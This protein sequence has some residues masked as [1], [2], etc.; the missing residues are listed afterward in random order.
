VTGIRTTK[1][2]PEDIF[3]REVLPDEKNGRELVETIDL[4]AKTAEEELIKQQEL[5]K[6][7]KTLKLPEDLKVLKQVP[8]PLYDIYYVPGYDEFK[9]G[10]IPDFNEDDN[11]KKSSNRLRTLAEKNI[12][13]NTLP[14]LNTSKLS[15]PN[16][17]ES[18]GAKIG[19]QINTSGIHPAKREAMNKTGEI[20]VK[21]VNAHLKDGTEYWQTTFQNNFPQYMNPSQAKA[22]Q[23]E[24][25]FHRLPYETQY[26]LGASEYR[27]SYG[28]LGSNP[29]DKLP[30]HWG[31]MQKREDTLKFGTTEC[32]N[33]PPGYTGFI[34]NT[35]VSY[36]KAIDQAKGANSRETFIKKNI[37]ENFHRQIPGY[38]GHKPRA[39]MND[40]GEV[41]DSIYYSNENTLRNV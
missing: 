9:T 39:A 7:S 33:H 22:M 1:D 34:P 19:M 37:T 13:S 36:G 17:N 16:L 6:A 10:H 2:Y 40:R 41:R 30:A 29:R 5:E 23:P 26:K 3:P 20:S 27:F 38:S 35:N 15:N 32:T 28:E 11:K 4:T 25:T 24:W 21:N 12:N 31:K 14:N 8:N 18:I